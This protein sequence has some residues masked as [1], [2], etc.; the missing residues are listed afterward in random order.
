MDSA[1][2]EPRLS[3]PGLLATL[4]GWCAMSAMVHTAS[5]PFLTGVL[6]ATV[7][8][9]AM[10]AILWAGVGAVLSLA[11]LPAY[12]RLFADPAPTVLR[13]AAMVALCAFGGLVFSELLQ[14]FDWPLPEPP[15]ARPPR[16]RWSRALPNTLSLLTFSALWLASWNVARLQQARE[17]QLR[18]ESHAIEARLAMLRLELDPH[19]LFNTLN[20]VIG[21]IDE[22]PTRAKQ[23]I[24]QLAELL[25]HTLDQASSEVPL[26]Q[27]LHTIGLYLAIERTR[28]EERLSVDFD[29]EEAARRVRVPAMLLQPLVEN[30]VKHGW[31]SA[32]EQLVIGVRAWLEGERLAVE[33]TNTGRLGPLGEGI[34]LR[35]L[36]ERL[37]LVAPEP[38]AFDLTEEQGR[39]VAALRLP[40]R[41]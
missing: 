23:M 35:N 36:R 37:A 33:I 7:G 31:R 17:G 16:A 21:T 6:G 32:P 29:V 13:I 2:R 30:A 22:S 12:R 27:E 4:V 39:V 41:T 9:V 10:R 28:F 8:Q 40:V 26:E 3:G 34:G 11:L 18:A 20:S 5:A 19:F 38:D 1:I 14:L 15:R 24:R 25:R